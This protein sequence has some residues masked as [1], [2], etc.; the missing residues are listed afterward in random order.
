MSNVF[1]TLQNTWL[2]WW[3]SKAATTT[4]SRIWAR[5]SWLALA[6]CQ[7]SQASLRRHQSNELSFHHIETRKS[8][9]NGGMIYEVGQSFWDG[10]SINFT[11]ICN[12]SDT[13]SQARWTYGVLL[14]HLGING[15]KCSLSL[16]LDVERATLYLCQPRPFCTCNHWPHEILVHDLIMVMV[17]GSNTMI[18]RNPCPISKPW[19]CIIVYSK[20]KSGCSGFN[21]FELNL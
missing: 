6:N 13:N 1:P 8:F 7:R 4:S 17:G 2:S 14:N 16:H 10:G 5:V 3:K 12:Y 20:L 9:W 11:K 21:C 19:S 15:A 18:K